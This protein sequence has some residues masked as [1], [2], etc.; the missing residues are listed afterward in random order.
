M[1]D[2]FDLITPLD[3]IAYISSTWSPRRAGM[4]FVANVKTHSP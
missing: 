2:R 4:L 3:D 1:G